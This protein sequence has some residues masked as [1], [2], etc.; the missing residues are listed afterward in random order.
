MKNKQILKIY[1][2]VVSPVIKELQKYC[3]GTGRWRERKGTRKCME[4]L[5][6]KL[7]IEI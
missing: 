7:S 6:S 1:H 4:Q 5:T 2:S 3:E